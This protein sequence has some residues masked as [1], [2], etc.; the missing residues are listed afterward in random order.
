MDNL[1][2][3]YYADYYFHY[4]LHTSSVLVSAQLNSA[5]RIRLYNDLTNIQLIQSVIVLCIDQI[6]FVCIT[7]SKYIICLELC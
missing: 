6:N 7:N 4:N 2:Y 5:H 1:L 3:F